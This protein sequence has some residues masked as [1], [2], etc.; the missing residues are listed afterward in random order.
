MEGERE[1]EGENELESLDDEFVGGIVITESSMG[2]SSSSTLS[3][4]PVGRTE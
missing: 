4:I 3:L 2:S 1:L